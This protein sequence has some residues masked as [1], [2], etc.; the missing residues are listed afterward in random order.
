MNGK[1]QDK[2]VEYIDAL[3]Q[4]LGVAV[5]FVFETLIKQQIISGITTLLLLF[6]FY[7]IN[8]TLWIV[9]VK[10]YVKA[11]V[12]F[13]QNEFHPSFGFIIGAII[14]SFILVLATLISLPEAIKQIINPEYY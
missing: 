10:W 9:G 11:G 6:I 1:I 8:T 5:E 7:A 12:S 3:A 4:T 14:L 13:D 2:I